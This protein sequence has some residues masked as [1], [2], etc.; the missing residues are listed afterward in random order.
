MKSKVYSS[1]VKRL[2][3]FI[4]AL[5]LILAL[6]PLKAEAK[7]YNGD[8]GKTY[9]ITGKVVKHKYN[10]GDGIHKFTSYDLVLTKKIKVKSEFFGGTTK[11]KRIQ[12]N[13]SKLSTKN[14]K[15]LKKL[16]GKKVKVT[17]KFCPGMTAW[18]CEDFAIEASKFKKVK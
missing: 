18:Y 4:L 3:S 17:G 11:V 7:T 1:G 8:G 16:V 14:Q 5:S 15:K 10:L 6:V 13:M 12:I 9:T 2:L